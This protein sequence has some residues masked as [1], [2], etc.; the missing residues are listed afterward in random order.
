MA[1]PNP[2]KGLKSISGLS[3]NNFLIFLILIPA[4]VVL[5]LVTAL[6][7]SVGGGILEVIAGIILTL[8]LL[9]IVAVGYISM[10]V[11]T[12]DG[13][14][15][16]LYEF[17]GQR[18][19][20]AR[21]QL[22]ADPPSPDEE[23]PV[24]GTFDILSLLR[25]RV[26]KGLYFTLVGFHQKVASVDTTQRTLSYISD[27]KEPI[28][29]PTSIAT[30]LGITSKPSLKSIRARV[31]YR[32]INPVQMVYNVNDSPNNDSNNPGYLVELNKLFDESIR[33]AV[34][35][36]EFS[37]D[38]FL[39]QTFLLG[40]SVTTILKDKVLSTN[41]GI[42]VGNVTVSNADPSDKILEARESS[43]IEAELGK[44]ALQKAKFLQKAT[45]LLMG[46][47]EDGTENKNIPVEMRLTR[48]EVLKQ[49][50][51]DKLLKSGLVKELKLN[52]FG[53]DL[54]ASVQDII[55]KRNS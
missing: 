27:P 33:E 44:G 29:L 10:G 13:S 39:S 9:C 48:E 12:T 40:P 4:T 46:Y 2:L 34:G 17:L 20:A 50:N 54:L 21:Y 14:E 25:P 49:E 55:S 7:L 32:G 35:K 1:T 15:V 53:S 5:I 45:M 8:I 41:M 6:I 22:T 42:W 36:S 26:V 51:L 3:V 31:A 43:G 18:P 37:L 28:D 19:N 30:E 11:G 16:E 24:D 52:T 23:V 47:N 38:Q